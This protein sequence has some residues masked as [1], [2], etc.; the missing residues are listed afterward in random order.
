VATG[1][2]FPDALAASALCG[3]RRG[4]LLL[5][6]AATDATFALARE[7]VSRGAQVTAIGGTAAVGESLMA[8]LMG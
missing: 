7:H 4:S 8:A 3:A 5:M 2:N 1:R 6:D